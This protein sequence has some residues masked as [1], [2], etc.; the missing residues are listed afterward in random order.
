VN[1]KTDFDVLCG[2]LFD[3]ERKVVILAADALENII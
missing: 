2:F 3:A 1:G